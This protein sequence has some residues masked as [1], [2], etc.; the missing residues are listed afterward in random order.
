MRDIDKMLIVFIIIMSLIYHLAI[1]IFIEK[2]AFE[3]QEE[4]YAELY[5]GSTLRKDFFQ[6]HIERKLAGYYIPNS[7][8]YCVW[9]KGHTVDEINHTD[10]HEM[11]H[12]LI[13]QDPEHF[14][15]RQC[16]RLNKTVS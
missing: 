4:A 14:C 2:K 9:L 10:Y 13:W 7:E 12:H 1:A 5:G 8:Y 3:I 16:K 11:C 15:E 6:G